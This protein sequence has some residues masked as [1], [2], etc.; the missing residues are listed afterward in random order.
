M[1]HIINGNWKGQLSAQHNGLT[2]GWLS[3]WRSEG[4]REN[5]M[6]C[7]REGSI[8][9]ST[10]STIGQRIYQWGAQLINKRTADLEK[11]RKRKKE[12]KRK[13]TK[14]KKK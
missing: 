8:V 13:E 4:A 6:A 1:N 3:V 5:A 14:K 10:N 2:N 9:G 11:E 12:T 7:S